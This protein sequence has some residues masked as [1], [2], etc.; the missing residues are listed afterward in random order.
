[1]DSQRLQSS[2]Q[3][4]L[5]GLDTQCETILE[6]LSK[7]PLQNRFIDRLVNLGYMSQ[8]LPNHAVVHY[9]HRHSLRHPGRFG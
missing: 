1:M 8:K 2:G 5:K 6:L 4:V 3:G 7:D 9:N